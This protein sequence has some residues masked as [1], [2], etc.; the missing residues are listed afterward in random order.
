[1][2]VWYV[3][4]Y[5]CYLDECEFTNTNTAFCVSDSYLSIVFYPPPSTKNIMYAS[6]DFVP[7]IEVPIPK[8]RLTS[9]WQHILIIIMDKKVKHSSIIINT[10]P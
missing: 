5:I 6:S 7:D 2:N 8:N 10:R 9:S 1:M 3:L 4:E